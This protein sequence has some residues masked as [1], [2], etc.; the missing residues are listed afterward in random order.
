MRLRRP[1]PA[2]LVALLSL[3]VALGGSS[4]AALK[5]PKASVGP[6]QLKKNS[7]TSPKV[8]PGTLLLSDFKRSHR[9][10][11]RGSQGVQGPQGLQ[12]AAGAT[13]VTVRYA[14]K[15]T[16]ASNDSLSVS[17]LPGE[18]ATGG[19]AWLSSGVITTLFFFRPGGVPT[20]ETQA[21]TPTGWFANW[22]N[23]DNS[24]KTIRVAAICA[25]P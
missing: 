5:L 4:Y 11:L 24:S 25:A 17:C 2:M 10:S 3:F 18:R 15:T 9:A 13:N 6:K 23:S 14:E 7:V 21:A 8:K 12:G 16:S 1:S 20:P 19:S 22:F